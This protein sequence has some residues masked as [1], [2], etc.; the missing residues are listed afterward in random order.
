MG[1]IFP[2]WLL[3]RKDF[4]ELSAQYGHLD[5]IDVWEVCQRPAHTRNKLEKRAVLVW[6]SD[7][8]FLS[9]MKDYQLADICDRFQS[10]HFAS[11]EALVHKGDLADCMYILVEGY[12]GI[13]LDSDKLVDCIYPKN[14]IGEV[15]VQ[16]RAART[17]TVVAIVG[18]KAFKLSAQDYELAV[19]KLKL[20]HFKD[21]SM[22]L[23]NTPFFS[24]WDKVKVDRL[25][26]VLMIKWYRKG[27]VIYRHGESPHAM[28]V[29]R[30]GR[31][32]LD[33]EATLERVN[34][35]PRSPKMNEISTV[36]RV[37]QRT[38]REC[39]S[40]DV[41]GELEMLNNEQRCCSATCMEN[42]LIFAL[43]KESIEEIFTE[44]EKLKLKSFNET[45]PPTA[46]ILSELEAEHTR[47][48][49]MRDALLNGIEANFVPSTRVVEYKDVR[50]QELTEI[51][52]ERHRRSK[53]RQL[54]RQD[55]NVEVVERR[56][57]LSPTAGR[58]D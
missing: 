48:S 52:M 3:G 39:K 49:M 9:E 1:T 18:V 34:Q 12:V 5:S 38:L 27:Q 32:N 4:Q 29:L 44:K 55:K 15:G 8:P 31:V 54:V 57:H 24:V 35:W 17:A 6:M 45:R 20:Q 23:R 30:E 42:S 7:S 43:R 37:Y 53:Q 41:F 2:Q 22:F 56:T 16:S 47:A 50:K 11:G 21:Q 46:Q 14:V 36:H 28:Y 25:A 58:A 13:Y 51:I 10:V 19:F 40:G 33:A 26:S